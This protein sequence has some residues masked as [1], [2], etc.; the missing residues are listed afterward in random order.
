MEVWYATLSDP[1]SR[2]ALWVHHETVAPTSGSPYLHGWVTWFPADGPPRT[3]RFGPGL[4][5]LASGPDWFSAVN[6]RCG[7]IGSLTPSR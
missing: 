7:C 5:K 6:A 4:T 1:V 3:E 2:A